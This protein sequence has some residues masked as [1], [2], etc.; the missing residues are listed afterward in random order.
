LAN[1][2][3]PFDGRGSCARGD[4]G[5][6]NFFRGIVTFSRGWCPEFASSGRWNSPRVPWEGSSMSGEVSYLSR[7]F[8]KFVEISAAGLASAICAYLLAHFGGLLSSP[9]PASAP[10]FPA[11]QA[12]PTANEAAESLRAKPTPPAA[13]AAVN[14]Q[15]P[16]PQ[17]DTNASVAQPALK[18]VKD[19]KALPR[20]HTKTD[21]SVAEQEPGGQKSA[22]ALARA[23]L[24][25]VDAN[26][27]APAD[28]LI[29]PDLTDTRSAPVKVHPRRANV[30]PRQD[31]VGPPQAVAVPPHAAGVE[32]APHAADVQ[33]SRWRPVRRP[34]PTCSRVLPTSGPGRWPLSTSSGG[35]SPAPTR[36]YREPTRRAR[37]A[38]PSS[39]LQPTRT[40]ARSTPSSGSPIC[41]APTRRRLPGETPRPPMPVGTASP[42]IK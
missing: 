36:C 14:E 5:E 35:R 26:R 27:P 25:N 41:C 23:A 1:Q 15:R 17:Q 12:S 33:L 8:V 39:R 34:A 22:E 6:L 42:E 10:A 31:D 3:L 40:R 9:T 32:S 24:A 7:F 20:K 18:G 11:V 28:A 30:P 19:A 2:N 29:A 38:R 16:A 37:L 21:M 13:A 4:A